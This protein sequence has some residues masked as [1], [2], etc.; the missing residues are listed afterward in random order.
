MQE[1]KKV[2][3]NTDYDN[4]AKEAMSLVNESLGIP[5]ELLQKG[6]SLADS[7]KIRSEQLENKLK[8]IKS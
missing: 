6:N 1:V 8:K 2:C 5:Y 7:V 4:L 3:E